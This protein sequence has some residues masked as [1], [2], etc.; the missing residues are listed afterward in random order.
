MFPIAPASLAL[1]FGVL[2]LL[3]GAAQAK[4]ADVSAICDRAGSYAAAK[5]G[6]PL[7]VMRA[8]TLTETGTRIEGQYRPWPWT[9][10]MEGKGIWFNAP[11]EALAYVNKHFTRGARSFDVGCFQINYRWHGKAFSS[12]EDMF[13]PRKNALYAAQ[14]LRSLYQET[15]SWSKSAGAYHSRTPK[16][17][18][19]YRAR[20]DRIIARLTGQPEPEV[21]ADQYTADL[22]PTDSVPVVVPQEPEEPWV[23]PPPTKY[24]S[25]AGLAATRQGR[26]LLPRARR[27]LF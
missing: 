5:T 25:L 17:A 10:N 11:D 3:S 15:G 7:A 6:V 12:V 23:A 20:F 16:F 2:L 1:V 26:S 14:F 21:Q 18:N 19:R 27:G 4:T 9:V 13:D 22:Q 8:I 24:G